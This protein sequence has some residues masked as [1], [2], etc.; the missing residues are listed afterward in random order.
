MWQVR[1]DK[2]EVT[3]SRSARDRPEVG[4]GSTFVQVKSRHI[5]RCRRVGYSKKSLA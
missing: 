1:G 4:E 3:G 5:V 2:E